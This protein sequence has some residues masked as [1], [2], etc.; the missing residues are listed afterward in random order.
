M[1]LVVT[2]AA[3]VLRAGIDCGGPTRCP[4][5]A[6]TCDDLEWSLG[7]TDV[8]C[9]GLECLPCADGLRCAEASDCGSGVCAEEAE[10]GEREGDEREGAGRERPPRPPHKECAAP[11]CDD[12]VQNGSEE[13]VDCGGDCAACTP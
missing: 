12:L 8:D 11:A 7:E 3:G 1:R 6:G 10:G 13:G 4:R 5:C 9:G 2:A